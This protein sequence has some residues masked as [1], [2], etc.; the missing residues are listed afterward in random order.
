MARYVGFWQANSNEGDNK[1]CFHVQCVVNS[2]TNFFIVAWCDFFVFSLFH[3]LRAGTKGKVLEE[4]ARRAR[5][6]QGGR[7][8]LEDFA[9]FL[10]LPVTETL[11]QVHSLFDQVNT[12]RFKTFSLF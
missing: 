8:G 3:R 2:A 7:L 1:P 6:L 5:K 9:Q 4:Q 12:D 11:A 10:N